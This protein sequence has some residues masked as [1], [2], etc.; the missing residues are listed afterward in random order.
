[1]IK[2]VNECFRYC[3]SVVQCT[4]ENEEEHRLKRQSQILLS[5]A[6]KLLS[7]LVDIKDLLREIMFEAKKLTG[8]ERC[9]VFLVDKE[10]KQL[11]AKVFEGSEGDGKQEI[12]IR[13]S[14]GIAGHVATT[15]N[16]ILFNVFE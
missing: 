12:R 6:R 14:Q 4:Q 16:V 13:L 5:V 3:L 1:M 2:L 7:H 15:G 11:F 8:A 10:K 9:S